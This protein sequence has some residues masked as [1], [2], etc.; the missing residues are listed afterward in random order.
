MKYHHL[1]HQLGYS[2]GL[3]II[4][5]C[6]PI[7]NDVLA[8]SLPSNADINNIRPEKKILPPPK[9]I[10]KTPEIKVL[11]QEQAPNGAEKT[12][13]TL[14]DVEIEGVS[15]F[16]SDKLRNFY[17]EKHLGKE[18][19]LSKIYE[20]SDQI[21]NHYRQK[22]YFLTIA[23]I[24]PQSIKNG[25]VK[26]M[27]SE[28]YIAKV[29]IDDELQKNRIIAE[30]IKELTSIKPISSAKLESFLLRMNDLYGY[31]FNG[32]LAPNEDETVSNGVVLEL[33]KTNSQSGGA[34]SFDNFGSRFLGVHR[35]SANYSKS[36]TPL[37]QT[38]ATAIMS[39]P[40]NNLQYGSLNHS[41]VL[42]PALTLDVAGGITN[43]NPAFTLKPLQ[44]E[45]KA[46]FLSTKLNYQ[47]IRQRRE[48]LSVSLVVDGRNS[49]TDALQRKLTSDH[50]RAARLSTDFNFNDD[51]SGGYNAGNI[52]LSKGIPALGAT[53][54]GDLLLS[55]AEAKP[56]FTKLE[57]SFTHLQ[58]L[59]QSF[60]LKASFAGQL[61]S[62]PLY[63]SE[64]F[65]Y[66]GQAFGRAYDNSEIIG[67]HGIAGSLEIS[68]NDW[69]WEKGSITPY[70]F[71]DLGTVWNID[72]AQIGRISGSS[73]GGG[74]RFTVANEVQLELGLAFPL[75]KNASTPIY[76]DSPTA[77]R[78]YFQL[79]KPF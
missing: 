61:S 68:Y 78:I 37:H 62:S 72:K 66:G 25:V 4:I 42:A 43:A 49:T 67:D 56:N 16:S 11:P 8:Q 33:V 18:I 47:I 36:L 26:I 44:I 53:D 40:T 76:G 21:T 59:S 52:T 29:K 77:P 34:I 58:S 63:S 70:A 60:M 57:G 64:E 41:V 71:Y 73:A 2:I 22:G 10:G 3:G 17:V 54:A 35:L 28:G 31:Q 19:S 51:L 24:P 7:A 13:F 65:G 46:L 27:V 50:I 75:T 30:Y 55:R 6:A 1:F 79:V 5:M 38:S 48:N 32:V 15:A 12:I 23:Q 74:A 20:I 69:Q 9:I 39:M 45:S 14:N